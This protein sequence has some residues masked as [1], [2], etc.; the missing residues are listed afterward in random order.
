MNGRSI[1]DIHTHLRQVNR[2][3]EPLSI[4][5]SGEALLREM[6]PCGIAIAGILGFRVKPYQSAE[7]VREVNDH[8]LAVVQTAP[9]RLYGLCF[10]N[11]ELDPGFLKE[12]LDRCLGAPEFRGVKLEMCTNC[13]SS[14]LDLVMEKALEHRVPVLQHSWYLNMWELQHHPV[15]SRQ[16]MGR[17]EPH[18]VAALARRF[19]DAQ[20][21]MAHL[22]GSGIRGILDI[23]ECGNVVVDTSGS[24]PFT[25]TLEYAVRY[26]GH[27]RILFGSDLPGRGLGGQLGRIRGAQ[28]PAEAERAILETNA[29]KLFRL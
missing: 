4:R 10:V 18:D 29:R 6:D 11:P 17:S 19:P 27:E 2:Q 24:Q 25:G 26:L 12:E 22:E 9:E 1:I 23:A 7:E 13:R 8:T 28:L 5:Q 16:Q 20:I 15:A 3:G 14:K 21:I